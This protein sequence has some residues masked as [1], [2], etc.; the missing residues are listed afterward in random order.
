MFDRADAWRDSPVPRERMV[1]INQMAQAFFSRAFPHSWAQDY[2][3]DRLNVDLTDHP[4]VLPGYAPDRWTSLT[5]HL[6]RLGVT[7]EEMLTTGAARTA[8]TG[9]LIDAFRDRLMLPIVQD[10]EILGFVGRRHPRHDL[11]ARGDQRGGPKYLNT[12]ETPLFHKGDQFYGEAR[13][14]AL[15]V[16]VE[17]PLDAIAVTLGTGGRHTGLAPLGTALTDPQAAL[18]AGRPIILATDADQAGDRAA[19]R[20]FWRLAVHGADPTRATLPAGTDPAAILAGHGPDRLRAILDSTRPQADAMIDERLA[21]LPRNRALDGAAAV[22]A[23]RS[24]ASWAASTATVADALEVPRRPSARPCC[25]TSVPGTTTHDKPPPA[26]S[27]SPSG[28]PAPLPARPDRYHRHLSPSAACS[29]AVSMMSS[30]CR[31][32][33]RLQVHPGDRARHPTG[34]DTVALTQALR[35]AGHIGRATHD[36]HARLRRH[37]RPGRAAALVAAS[38]TPLPP[39]ARRRARTRSPSDHRWVL[40]LVPL[41]WGWLTFALVPMSWWAVLLW[42]PL[43]LALAW[44]SAV[45]LDVR[46][47]PDRSLAAAGV[48]T[49]VVLGLDAAIHD[50]SRPLVEAAAAAIVG[51]LIFFLL[52]LA[53]PDGLGFGDVKLVAVLA[54]ASAG[55]DGWRTVVAL[56][57]LGCV[58]ALIGMA[59]TRRRDIAFGPC[60]GARLGDHRRGDRQVLSRLCRRSQRPGAGAGMLR[61]AGREC[62]CCRRRR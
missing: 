25:V 37:R 35:A 43:S 6:R 62:S 16:I 32:R 38:H 50:Q 55:T 45:D 47:L 2:L 57:L 41:S 34:S 40:L 12:S 15:P 54:A 14:D 10:G 13:A 60:L 7:D 44:A 61:P 17:G 48:W 3:I 9:H 52:H 29:Q 42:L 19:D 28:H 33:P 26:D 46:R 36:H 18:L 8:S 31:R 24:P 27:R 21:G 51:G 56:T 53:S 1:E 39:A 4:A 49:A 59:A 23:A 30:P 5:Q 58:T 20:D 11:R 22:I